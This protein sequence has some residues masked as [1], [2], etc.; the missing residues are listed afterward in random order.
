MSFYDTGNPVPSID[1]R[2]LDDNAKHIDELVNSTFPTFVDRQ[3]TTRRTLAG[4]EADADAIVLRDELADEADPELGAAMV[5]RSWQSADTIA[6]LRTLRTDG[7]SR[8]ATTGGYWTL[9][10]GGSGDYKVPSS[11]VGLV[12][13][14][15][16]IEADDGGFW[17]LIHNGSVE[18]RQGGLRCDGATNDSAVLTALIAELSLIGPNRGA[19]IQLTPRDRLRISSN[20]TFEGNTWI[21]GSSGAGSNLSNLAAAEIVLGGSSILIDSGVTV[22]PKGSSRFSGVTFT[23]PLITGTLINSS[24]FAG[25]AITAGGDDIRF[26]YCAFM[27]FDKA[28]FSDGFA[29]A[30]FDHCNFDVQSGIDIRNSFDVPRI[31]QCQFWPWLTVATGNVGVGTANA[32]YRSGKAIYMDNVSWPEVD[33]VFTFGYEMGAE[34]NN[35]TNPR[36]RA[37]LEGNR[38]SGGAIV[39]TTGCLITGTTGNGSFS[40]NTAHQLYGVRQAVNTGVH[41]KIHTGM[42][43]DSSGAGILIETGDA[44]LENNSTTGLQTGVGG[45]GVSVLST[46]G[47]VVVPTHRT[48]AEA[49]GIRIANTLTSVSQIFHSGT[50]TPVNS[51]MQQFQLTAAATLLVRG[52]NDHWYVAGTTG[53]TN[54][55]ETFNGHRIT[56]IFTQAL[57]LTDGAGAGAL[58]VGGSLAV[59]AGQTLQFVCNGIS[60]AMTW[61]RIS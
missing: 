25:T 46:A 9:G 44:T 13:G 35:C 7:P 48:Q 10:D 40:I 24:T 12:D 39:P 8:F 5:A 23:N 3:G 14:L 1:P 4:I 60:G 30:A 56:V 36:V 16:T 54:F 6:Q 33:G 42:L 27:G 50:T 19:A 53:I 11:F 17:Q 18:A 55:S 47:V 26:D 52:Y 37:D 22:T 28:F 29:R 59:T 38:D 15:L 21:K 2:D 20:T 32:F 58:R 51:T 31:T 49:E 43:R 45:I 61:R 34:F 41:N 57:T